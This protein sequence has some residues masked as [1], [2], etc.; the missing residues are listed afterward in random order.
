MLF[1]KLAEIL[2]IILTDC[3]PSMSWAF[4][5]TRQALRP[6]CAQAPQ[7]KAPSVS[8]RMGALRAT[9]KAIE[10]LRDS[11]LAHRIMLAQ[12]VFES[13]AKI[14]IA[15]TPISTLDASNLGYESFANGWTNFFGALVEAEKIVWPH[16]SHPSSVAL[17]FLGPLVASFTL[18]WA[19]PLPGPSCVP[20]ILLVTDGENN[21]GGRPADCIRQANR[22]KAAGVRIFG[23]GIGDPEEFGLLRQLVSDP[24]E[25]FG[26]H[27]TPE[28]LKRAFAR[29]AQRLVSDR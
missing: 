18:D 19:K 25:D 9:H 17:P 4:N 28:S 24:D 23:Q 15:P 26:V 22:L 3:S 8:R 16:V 1:R 7:K 10:I 11:S 27:D 14:H 21:L 12:V 20:N 13:R 5:E 29:I 2:F 6:S